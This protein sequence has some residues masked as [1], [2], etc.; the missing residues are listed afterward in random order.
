M[1]TH[2]EGAARIAL[3]P[4]VFL[5]P[6]QVFNRDLSMLVASV[7]AADLPEPVR[8]LEPMAATGIRSIRYFKE[9][10][11]PVHLLANDLSYEAV[12]EI[13]SNFQDNGVEAEVRQMDACDLMYRERSSQ[14]DVIDLDPYG[15][16]ASFLDAAVQSVKSGGLICVTSTDMATLCGNN[17]DTCFYKYQS[18]P[19][20]TS[21]CHEFAL[22]ILLHQLAATA[23]RYQKHVVPLVSV[24]VDFYVRVFAQV[25]SSAQLAK[26]SLLRTAL[27]LQCSSCPAYYFQNMGRPGKNR[28]TSTLF[29]APN[30]CLE[31][32]GKLTLQGPIYSGKLHDKEFIQKL[33][34]KV[35]TMG[36]HTYEKV[37]G[38]LVS[39]L[40]ELDQPLSWDYSLLCKFFKVTMMSATQFRSA[41]KSLG[42]SISNL[43]TRPNLY[44]T[45]ATP[46]QVFHIMKSWVSAI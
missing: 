10:G 15:S 30:E 37:K 20:K 11:R 40:N 43:H 25:F 6:A 17:P 27:V 41:F 26:Q 44:K 45:D 28:P 24:S 36:L 12:T 35:E 22:R 3:K 2:I 46:S 39:M 32:S 7:Y 34:V 19:S 1:R 42:F 18:V 38:V 5:N 4:D 14:W 8:V 16:A 13:R 9:L 31:C 23:S 33:L 29:E 21:Y